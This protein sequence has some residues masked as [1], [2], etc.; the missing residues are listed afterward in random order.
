M[1]SA[2]LHLAGLAFLEHFNAEILPR[3]AELG[4]GLVPYSPLG[5]GF[6]TGKAAGLASRL[7]RLKQIRR[8]STWSAKSPHRSMRHRPRSHWPGS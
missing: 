8:W 5:K 1:A 4:I 3:L 2:A 7:K 6:L